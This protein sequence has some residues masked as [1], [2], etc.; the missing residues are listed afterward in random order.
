MLTLVFAGGAAPT[1]GTN[2]LVGHW[3]D[4]GGTVFARAYSTGNLHWSDC[5]RLGIF[6]FSAGSKEVRVWPDP[7]TSQEAIIDT[8]SRAVQPIVLQALGQQALHAGAV[9]G[10][11]G[12]VAFCGAKGSGKSTLAFA[13]QQ[14]GWQQFADD[15]LILRFDR[16]CVTACPLPFAPRLR[17]DSR[18]HFADLG[19]HVTATQQQLTELPLS[20]VFLLRQSDEVCNP[21]VS[22]MQASRALS[23]LIAHAHFFDAG[24]LAHMRQLFGDYL[25]LVSR[26]PIFILEYRP[27]FQL[28]PQMTRA[29]LE[30]MISA[31]SPSCRPLFHD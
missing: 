8:F 12:V 17:R 20:A 15:A 23:E 4:E 21:R 27:N 18:A 7:E 3:I 2:R 5:S 24:D 6:V 28:L 31:D 30:A 16:L 13:M 14:A 10:P 25:G 9:V 11:A 22:L 19:S 29:V 26:V 1:A